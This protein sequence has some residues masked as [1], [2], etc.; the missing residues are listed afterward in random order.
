MAATQLLK[1]GMHQRWQTGDSALQLELAL[2]KMVVLM[3]SPKCS[4]RAARGPFPALAKEDLASLACADA[5]TL[6]FKPQ[7]QSQGHHTLL[8]KCA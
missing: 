8:H 7:Q 3:G 5:L 2:E 6:G 1:Q 4:E